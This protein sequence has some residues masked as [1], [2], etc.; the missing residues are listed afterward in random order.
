MPQPLLGAGIVNAK[1]V[2]GTLGC[3]AYTLHTGEPVL[4]SS[5][6]VLFGR[7]ANKASAVWLESNNG[8]GL[9]GI[10]K[11]LY[12]KIGTVQFSGQDYY[13]DCAVA[14]LTE[15]P[16]VLASHSRTT[17]PTLITQHG[18]A[19]VGDAV[20]KTGAA[21][22]VTRGTVADVNYSESVIPRG[23]AQHTPGQLLLKPLDQNKVFSAEGDSGAVVVDAANKA[24][25]LLWG[26]NVRGEGIACPIAPVLYA[27]NIT[28]EPRA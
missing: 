11:T 21:T 9:S 23:Q 5:W 1:G 13:L 24:I 4:L 14:S 12:G 20:I 16:T 22:G 25:G 2:P 3:I 6:H 15:T 28:L 27:M 18:A 17:L 7:D 8:H 10:G 26:T 19:Q